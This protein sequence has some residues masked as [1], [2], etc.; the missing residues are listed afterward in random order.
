MHV[1][2][3]SHASA[4][5]GGLLERSAALHDVDD[6]GG[7]WHNVASRPATTRQS[8]CVCWHVL[9]QQVDR[10]VCASHE[11]WMLELFTA[12]ACSSCPLGLVAA[13]FDWHRHHR[14]GHGWCSSCPA[15][16]LMVHCQCDGVEECQVVWDLLVCRRK[17]LNKDLSPPSSNDTT[18]STRMPM[19]STFGTVPFPCLGFLWPLEPP[20]GLEDGWA[21]AAVV[22]TQEDGIIHRNRKP[23]QPVY[24]LLTRVHLGWFTG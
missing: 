4:S 1:P 5:N 3:S 16:S 20:G 17:L 7:A 15:K 8:L 24:V 23:S 2:S 9:S 11:Q 12:L 14:Q 22:L 21:T 6:M 18:Q 10:R 19:V 13:D